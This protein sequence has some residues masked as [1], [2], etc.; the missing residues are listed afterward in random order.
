[1]T[2]NRIQKKV[3]T[4]ELKSRAE[5]GD[6]EA[7]SSLGLLYELGLDVGKADPKEA[8]KWWSKA[9]K[10]G[11]AQAQFALAEI[12][13]HEF[14]DN[15]ENR[16]M[17]HALYSK[18]EQKGHLRIDKALRFFGREGGKGARILI[19]DESPKV[20][21][22]M[23]AMVD[24]EGAVGIPASSGAEALHILRKSQDFGLVFVELDMR[25]MTGLDFVRAVR[26]NPLTEKLPIVI[27]AVTNSAEAVLKAK[28]L[29]ISGWIV[30]P[31]KPAMITRYLAKIDPL[32][33]S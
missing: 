32:K 4:E 27:V 28:Q 20:L 26:A 10:A 18:A 6:V 9:A 5:A 3:T 25:A 23:K 1:M 11:D 31:I 33:T 29:G 21:H 7:Q 17:A 2:N 12:I 15:E 24:G 8:A 22:D 16:A 30:K 13:T 19:V 14:E